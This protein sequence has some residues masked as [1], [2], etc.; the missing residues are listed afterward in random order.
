MNGLRELAAHAA[1][2]LPTFRGKRR[3][4]QALDAWLRRLN[5]GAVALPL[6]VDGVRYEL[7]TEDLI[8]F[9]IAYLGGHD[10]GVVEFLSTQIR[11]PGTVLWDVGTNVGSI[12]LPL[13]RRH[14]QLRVEAFEPAPAVIERLRRNLALNPVLAKRM[15][16]HEAALCDRDGAVYFYVSAE[17]RNSGVG[18]LLRSDNTQPEPLRVTACTGDALIHDGRAS[19]PDLIKLDVEGF[20]REALV[21]LQAYLTERRD[22]VIVFEHEPYRV[23]V[24]NEPV[25]ATQFLQAMGFSLFGLDARGRKQPFQPHMLQ[26]RGD[27]VALRS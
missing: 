21:G 16:V 26:R 17:S 20:E 14:S 4:L 12:S 13:L 3:A 24:R 10:R 22:V 11:S 9:N 2:C 8:D 6:S 7:D 1:H 15:R 27:L 5:S 23:N 25:G 18:T 19:P